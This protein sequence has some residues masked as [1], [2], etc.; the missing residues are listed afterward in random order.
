MPR[1]RN[2]KLKQL[3]SLFLEGLLNCKLHAALYPKKH[4]TLNACIKEAVKLDDNVDEFRDERPTGLGDSGSDKSSE[5]KVVAQQ[6]QPLTTPSWVP[7]VQE[8]ANEILK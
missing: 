5:T 4:K 8:V 1:D 6:N 2:P 7:T 3:V